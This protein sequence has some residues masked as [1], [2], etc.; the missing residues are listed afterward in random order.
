MQKNEYTQ[1]QINVHIRSY[2]KEGRENQVGIWNEWCI[3]TEQNQFSSPN[4]KLDLLD[5]T[6][7]FSDEKK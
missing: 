7:W 4:K 2:F 5:N 1:I 3:E 6:V